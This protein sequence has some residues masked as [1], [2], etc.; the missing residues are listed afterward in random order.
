[1]APRKVVKSRSGKAISVSWPVSFAPGDGAYQIPNQFQGLWLAWVSA[2]CGPLSAPLPTLPPSLHQE[3]FPLLQKVSLQWKNDH[4]SFSGQRRPPSSL[5]FLIS[6][7]R[8]LSPTVGQPRISTHPRACLPCPPFLSHSPWGASWLWPFS[9]LAFPATRLP[10]GKLRL[11]PRPC[12]AVGQTCPRRSMKR[13]TVNSFTS[14]LCASWWHH[15]GCRL[16]RAC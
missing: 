14:V 3:A 2:G 11:C 7:S 16:Q 4:C 1:M 5:S 15:P 13:H 6:C 9:P 10:V 8:F 12:T